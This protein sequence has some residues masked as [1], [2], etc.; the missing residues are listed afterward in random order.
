MEG[1]RAMTEVERL[2]AEVERLRAE[3]ALLERIADRR[4]RRVDPRRVA[5]LHR[6]GLSDAQIGAR[7]EVTADA[8]L[9][10]RRRLELAAHVK[11]RG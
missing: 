3:I 2:R 6:Q 11:R 4:M 9:Y 7:L 10:W 8:V 5:A 1:H